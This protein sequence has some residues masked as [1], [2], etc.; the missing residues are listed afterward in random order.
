MLT[1]IC[2]NCMSVKQHS[3][4]LC[5]A[6][7]TN[8]IIEANEPWH[9]QPGCILKERYLI[10][11]SI[12]YGGFGVTYIAFD[13]ILQLKVAIKEYL[14]SE[15]ATRMPGVTKVSV[16]AGE[17]EE[18]YN[19]GLEGFMNEAQKLAKF[20]EHRGIVKIQDFFEENETAYLVMEYIEG[21]T[22]KK[23]LSTHDGK[24]SFN[25]A[26]TLLMPVIDALCEVHKT[27]IIHRDISPDNILLTGEKEVK[28]IDF[29]AARYATTGHT[30]SL[31]V[32]LKPGYAPE[33]QYR[34]R[35]DQGPWSDIYAV[36]ATL[37]RMI[38]GIVPDEALK[39]I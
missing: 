22:F 33:E 38:T 7:G 15:F 35:G 30:K 10:G 4:E 1:N 18:Q 8:S 16:Y 32:I 27:G 9:L 24:I 12:G 28:L 21:V 31:S 25:E 34:S 37:Y 5:H 6:C 19:H 13:L 3:D 2:L 14:P 39:L 36:G 11:Y 20:T 17:K 23:Y 29:G 26:L